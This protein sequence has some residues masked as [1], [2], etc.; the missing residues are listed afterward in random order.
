MSN[1]CIVHTSS[2]NTRNSTSF[3]AN[4]A[5]KILHNI[6]TKNETNCVCANTTRNDENAPN[7]WNYEKVARTT[8]NVISMRFSMKNP[9]DISSL[10]VPYRSF[11]SFPRSS[12]SLKSLYIY[13]EGKIDEI[14]STSSVWFFVQLMKSAGA[15]GYNLLRK[16][17]TTFSII[18]FTYS[19]SADLISYFAWWIS[20]TWHSIR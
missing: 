8:A 3:L 2:A 13:F 4:S 14:C 20:T 19:Q 15:A 5:E 6:T 9:K 11:E 17:S 1:A 18:S 12:H 10:C 7:L 16:L